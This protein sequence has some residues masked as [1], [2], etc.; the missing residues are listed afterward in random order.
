MGC[1]SAVAG[2]LSDNVCASLTFL[3]IHEAAV[4]VDLYHGA[5]RRPTAGRAW[6]LGVAV[7]VQG[8]VPHQSILR[9]VRDASDE[10]VS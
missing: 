9:V 1:Q 3:V 8:E 10:A 5:T 2:E 6:E 7:A 4:A